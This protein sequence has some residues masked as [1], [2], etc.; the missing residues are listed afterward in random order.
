MSVR[1]SASAHREGA[2]GSRAPSAD[3]DGRWQKDASKV[4]SDKGT[5]Y[6]DF[7]MQP[8]VSI[9]EDMMVSVAS[10]ENLLDSATTTSFQKYLLQHS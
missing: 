7:T 5:G 6:E 3:Q 4:K 8:P 2:H 9:G 10:G 1:I